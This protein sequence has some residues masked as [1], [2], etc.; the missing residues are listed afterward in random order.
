MAI[1]ISA[2][3]RAEFS[4]AHLERRVK[5]FVVKNPVIALTAAVGIGFLG[6]YW[7]ARLPET[8]HFNIPSPGEVH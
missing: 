8:L 4:I 5:G 3:A 7:L 1:K 6:S 2:P